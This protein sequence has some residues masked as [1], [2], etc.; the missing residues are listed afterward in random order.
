MEWLWFSLAAVAV[1]NV[2]FNCAATSA[3]LRIRDLSSAKRVTELCFIWGVPLVGW[4]ITL[5]WYLGR[6]PD[7]FPARWLPAGMRAWFPVRREK[8]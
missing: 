3:L 1:V 8:T 6:Q 5:Q 4:V 2:Y 7:A